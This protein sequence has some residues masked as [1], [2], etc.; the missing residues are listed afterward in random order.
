[1]K[2][3]T[4]DWLIGAGSLLLF[5][6]LLFFV[7][8]YLKYILV[9]LCA[10]SALLLVLDLFYVCAGVRTQGR[11]EGQ[12]TSDSRF[13]ENDEYGFRRHPNVVA[14]PEPYSEPIVTGIHYQAR[15]SADKEEHSFILQESWWLSGKMTGR[16]VT[17]FYLPWAPQKVRWISIKWLLIHAI[18]PALFLFLWLSDLR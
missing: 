10:Y 17:L 11:V 15:S 12:R 13:Y 8:L 7:F 4:R 5:A 14:P 9:A 3:K 2:H 16:E 18:L 1:M 6:V